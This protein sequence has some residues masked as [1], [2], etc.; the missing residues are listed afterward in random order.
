MKY[1]QNPTSVVFLKRLSRI[2]CHGNKSGYL[3]NCYTI[4]SEIFDRTEFLWAKN[5]FLFLPI[6]GITFL[7]GLL[8]VLFIRPLVCISKR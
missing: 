8:D 5:D 4:S 7:R 6:T 1:L 2:S 3:E